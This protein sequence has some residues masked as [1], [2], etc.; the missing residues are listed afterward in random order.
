MELLMQGIKEITNLEFLE[1][2]L[3]DNKL[4]DETAVLLGEFVEKQG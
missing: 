4:K 2:D 3:F 1:L